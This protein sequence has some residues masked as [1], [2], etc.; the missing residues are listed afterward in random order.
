MQYITRRVPFIARG[1]SVIAL[2]LPL[3]TPQCK[4]LFRQTQDVSTAHTD[5]WYVFGAFRLTQDVS[6]AHTD[7]CYMFFAPVVP[8][9][10]VP[11]AHTDAF[12]DATHVSTC[13]G[14][15]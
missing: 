10:D 5:A 11:T 6:T 7:A 13:M 15:P 1:L 8:K 12:P 4:M 2:W 9:P 14:K 3:V